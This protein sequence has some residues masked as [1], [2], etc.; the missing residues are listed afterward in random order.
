MQST[1]AVDRL[2]RCLDA[3]TLWNGDVNALITIDAAS[4]MASAQ[5]VDRAASEGR[6]PGLLQGV[7]MVIKDNIDT[8]GLRTTYGSGF[9]RD[10][11]PSRDA[12]VVERLRR[13]G[14]IIVGKANLHEFAFGIRSTN[15]VAGQCR[16]PW[17]TT[18][19]PGGSSGGSAVA[20]ATG[21]A[22]MALGTDTAS[23]IR[24]PAA[25]T[26]VSGFRPTT[27]SVSNQGC[28][29]VSPSHD[30]IG[31]MARR[32]E[33]IARVLLVIAGHDHADPSSEPRAVPGL[34]SSLHDGIAGIRIGR[35]TSYYYEGLD[36]DVRAALDD[37]AKTFSRLGAEIVDVDVP[38][39]DEIREPFSVMLLCD[40]C[41]VHADRISIDSDCWSPQTLERMRLGLQ[42]SGVD[43]ARA[44][45]HRDRWSR[46]LQDVFEKVDLLLSPT[47]PIVAPAIQDSRNLNELTR[48]LARNNIP[49][50]Y[51][52]IPGLSIPCGASAAGL[53]IGLQLESARWNDPLVLRAGVAFQSVTD[54]HK[55]V[56]VRGTA[57]P[58]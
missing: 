24:I 40:A 17:D 38:G 46:T 52:R 56:P 53:P 54:W 35:P 9:F 57:K 23:S 7:P 20:I 42:F 22:E 45:S 27:G 10:H 2:Q 43:Y 36:D 13:A 33:D 32:V 19:I 1:T 3:A 39:V 16:N 15:P 51:G 47:C 55:R 12:F 18:R 8:A 41:H 25:L 11:V 49:G 29:P 30:V 26:G 44:L 6:P 48:A 58:A 50:A 21:M 14:A 34:L 28:L 31:P 5:A 4:A 37:A